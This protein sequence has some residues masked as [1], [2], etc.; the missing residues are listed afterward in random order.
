MFGTVIQVMLNFEYLDVIYVE[1]A[2]TV[3]NGITCYTYISQD[4]LH[5]FISYGIPWIPGYLST[6]LPSL[7]F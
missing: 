3:I 2:V 1:C 4:G 6:T 5:S 7:F